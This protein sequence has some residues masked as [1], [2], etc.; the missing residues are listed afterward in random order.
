MAE[1]LA[2]TGLKLFAM[3]L[4]CAFRGTEKSVELQLAY[5]GAK[6][7]PEGKLFFRISALMAY[8]GKYSYKL[9]SSF[10]RAVFQR[11]PGFIFPCR[12]TICFAKYTKACRR[13]RTT[14]WDIL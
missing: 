7:P 10:G 6:R 4:L 11:F 2:E 13:G 5:L 14:E 1:R 12:F 9:P 8:Y 3:A